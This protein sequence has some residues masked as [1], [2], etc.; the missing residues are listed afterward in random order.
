M[1]KTLA[2][3][4][5]AM[6]ITMSMFI[7]TASWAAERKVIRIGSIYPATHPASLAIAAMNEELIRRSNGTLEID[8]HG[9]SVLGD[10]VAL[11]QQV[12]M[13][14]LDGHTM[15]G[16]SA[17]NTWM[18]ELGIE[19]VPFLFPDLSFYRLIFILYLKKYI[20]N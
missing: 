15:L 7:S 16:L 9:N 10:D 6:I 5:I 14:A 20:C 11:T 3:V 17:Y 12:S 13:G 18:P 8:Y 4:S 19:D 2:F 1:K